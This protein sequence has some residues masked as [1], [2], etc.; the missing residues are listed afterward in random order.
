V[1]DQQQIE[2]VK[3]IARQVNSI[4]RDFR[5]MEAERDEIAGR[6]SELLWELTDGAMSKT[7]Y[8]VPTMVREVEATFE[9][10]CASVEAERDRALATLQRV[11]DLH[12]R[13][14]DDDGL[15]C[16]HC[17]ESWPCKTIRTIDGKADE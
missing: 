7:G 4:V 6:L 10:D 5:D 1:T 13:Q 3:A 11:R 2:T 8:D 14:V 17:C 12:R 9:K 15:F 16:T